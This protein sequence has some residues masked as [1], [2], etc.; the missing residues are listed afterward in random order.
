MP[1]YGRIKNIITDI[2]EYIDVD[3]F[4]ALVLGRLKIL[5]QIL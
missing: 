5:L 1:L 4:H 3:V 2:V